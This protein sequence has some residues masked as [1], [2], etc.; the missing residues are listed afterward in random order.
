[1]DLSATLAANLFG[2][3]APSTGGDAASAIAMLKRA[4]ATGAQAKGVAL[5]QKD[6]VVITALAQFNKAIANAKDLKSALADPR[7]LAVLLPG[8][9]MAD[10]IPYPGLAQR[11]LLA[12]P[13]AKTGILTQVDSRWKTAATTLGLFGKDLSALKDPTLQ[14]TLTKNYVSYQYQKSLD[15]Q[16]PGMS[17]ALYFI[18]NAAAQAGNVY[19][20]MGDAILRRVVTG[21]LELPA[22]LAVQPIQ[23]QAKAITS[24]LP[25]SKLT[26]PQQVYKIAQRYLMVTAENPPAT[27]TPDIATLAMSLRA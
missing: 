19:N 7:V 23:D 24:R 22:E 27:T 5:E 21:S 11:A 16:Q 12:D 1:M 26:D 9:G 2:Y 4:T 15:A 8:V 14:Q 6:P 10:Q 3:A 13:T 18:N 17:D 25:M 20:V